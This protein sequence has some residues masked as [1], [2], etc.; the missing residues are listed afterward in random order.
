VLVKNSKNLTHEKVQHV[1]VD[2]LPAGLYI[3]ELALKDELYSNKFFV[4]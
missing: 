4:K 2:D 3:I 1:P